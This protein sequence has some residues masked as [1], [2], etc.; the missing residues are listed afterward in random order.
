MFSRSVISFLFA[1]LAIGVVTAPAQ[2]NHC[3]HEA[4]I[5]LSEGVE[6][7]ALFC[8][9]ERGVRAYMRLSQLTPGLPYTVWWVYFDNPQICAVP[10]MCGD[11]DIQ[12]EN[13]LGVFGRMDSTVAR[14][15]GH[16]W[17]WGRI[18][19]FEP[20][21]GA[22]FWLLTLAHEPLDTEDGRHRAR[23]LLTPEDADFPPHLGNVVEGSQFTPAGVVFF[24]ID[25][26]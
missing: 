21:P 2:A 15:S 5:P 17:F 3:E 7:N 22:Q 23:Q 10:G 6:G 9:S 12:G 26:E 13:P 20:S 24:N 14:Q 25:G 11:A 8:A 4:V 16:E 1:L 18:G 19:G